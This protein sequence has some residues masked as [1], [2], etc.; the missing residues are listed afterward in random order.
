MKVV[1][2]A[3]SIVDLLTQDLISNN[4]RLGL[5]EAGKNHLKRQMRDKHKLTL[6]FLL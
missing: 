3:V 1:I 5:T 6:K 2:F 4:D